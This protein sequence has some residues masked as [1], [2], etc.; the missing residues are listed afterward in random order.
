MK[1][2]SIIMCFFASQLAFAGAKSG[3]FDI[4]NAADSKVFVKSKE[5][6]NGKN[7][8]MS[9]V[10]SKIFPQIRGVGLRSGVR[11]DMGTQYPGVASAY[12]DEASGLIELNW[13]WGYLVN[14]NN[15]KATFNVYI[16]ENE[17]SYT[18]RLNCPKVIVSDVQSFALFGFPEWDLNKISN[19][20]NSACVAAEF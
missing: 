7:V 18:I 16:E 11:Y 6:L 19:D 20:V 2:F 17:T 4:S 8:T 1:R 12:T 15:V 13:K 10:L 9:D 3:P 14:K 5:I